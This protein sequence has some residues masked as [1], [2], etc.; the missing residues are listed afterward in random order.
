[1]EVVARVRLEEV[2]GRRLTFAVEVDDERD[3]ICEGRHQRFV[4]DRARFESG[5]ERKRTGV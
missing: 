2:D 4:I 3:R 5:V 1:M